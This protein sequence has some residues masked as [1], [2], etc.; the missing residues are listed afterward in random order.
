MMTPKDHST[1]L[2]LY[3]LG[4]HLQGMVSASVC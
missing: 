4:V 2:P 3:S 1:P